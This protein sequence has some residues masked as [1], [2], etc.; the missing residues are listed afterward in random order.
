MNSHSLK[1]GYDAWLPGGGEIVS[2][3]QL[4]VARL[5]RYSRDMLVG[6]IGKEGQGWLL[7]AKVFVVGA[8]GSP[9]PR[10]F[11]SP[12]P[13]GIVNYDRVDL[14]NLNEKA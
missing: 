8:G 13:L 2:E 9:P 1:G 12:P 5:N 3:G 10:S 4:S 7:Q 6:E 14:S 11:T